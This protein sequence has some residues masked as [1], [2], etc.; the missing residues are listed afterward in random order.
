LALERASTVIE[1][2]LHGSQVPCLVS[3][4][5]ELPR[6]LVLVVNDAVPRT[7]DISH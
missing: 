3:V 7:A 2:R 1:R 5:T 6:I 4:V